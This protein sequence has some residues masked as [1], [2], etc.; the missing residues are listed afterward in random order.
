MHI[1][2][3]LTGENLHILKPPPF[4]AFL[5]IFPV[6]ISASRLVFSSLDGTLHV[7]DSNKG[8]LVYQLEPDVA[9]TGKYPFFAAFHHDDQKMV[10][11]SRKSLKLC[12]IRSGKLL[13]DLLPVDQVQHVTF[14][15][16]FCLARVVSDGVHSLEVWDFGDDDDED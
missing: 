13:M 16:H 8:S 3:L 5:H 7:W 15:G 2:D 9:Y 10:C 14:Q 11:G 6:T 1:W 4:R 12:D